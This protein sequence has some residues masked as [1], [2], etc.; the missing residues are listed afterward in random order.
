MNKPA[1]PN[2]GLHELMKLPDRVMVV[3]KGARLDK[4]FNPPIITWETAAGHPPRFCKLCVIK[5][6]D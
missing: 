3:P 1:L 6:E 5:K 2:D 4:T